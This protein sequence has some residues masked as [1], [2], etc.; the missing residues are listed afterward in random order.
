MAQSMTLNVSLH[1]LGWIL[2]QKPSCFMRPMTGSISFRPCSSRL[3]VGEVMPR[4]RDTWI[5]NPSRLSPW[6]R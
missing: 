4:V 5:S 2:L 6:P 1:D 3:M